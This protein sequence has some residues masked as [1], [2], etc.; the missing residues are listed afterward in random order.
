M[1]FPY[2]I[3][4]DK[5]MPIL[6]D[7]FEELYPLAGAYLKRYENSIKKGVET[8]DN[9]RWHLFTRAN[10]HQR[11]YPKVMLPMTA[12]DTFAN[13]TQNPLNY[14]DNANMFFIDIPEKSESNLYAVAGIINSILFSVIARSIALAQQNGYFKFNKQFIEPISFPKDVFEENT[15][16]VEEI[17]KLSK[18]IQ[19]KQESYKNSSPRQKNILRKVL[20]QLWDNLDNSVFELYDLSED[21]RKFFLKRGRNVDRV[22]ILDL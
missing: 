21:E 3:E 1:I 18:S 17:A 9:E 14:C 10:N 22:K 16:L 4:D 7:E 11:V 5:S 13:V 6:F 2:S 12:N 15:V 19:E 20:N 8:F